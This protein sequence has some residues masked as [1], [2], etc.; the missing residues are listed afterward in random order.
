MLQVKLPLTSREANFYVL[1]LGHNKVP[2]LPVAGEAGPAPTGGC[3]GILG[4]L[5][6]LHLPRGE[7]A[8]LGLKPLSEARELDTASCKDNVAK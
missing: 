1:L 7:A 8:D 4:D 2:E 3:E 6:D 5:P